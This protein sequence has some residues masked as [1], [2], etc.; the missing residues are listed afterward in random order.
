MNQHIWDAHIGVKD[1]Q[2]GQTDH[3]PVKISKTKNIQGLENNT[4]TQAHL[5]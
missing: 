5:F 1:D 4:I 2:K 3:K